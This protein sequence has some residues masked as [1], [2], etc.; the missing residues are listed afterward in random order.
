MDEAPQTPMRSGPSEDEDLIIASTPRDVTASKKK[1]KTKATKRT[2]RAKKRQNVEEEQVTSDAT[3]LL[4]SSTKKQRATR[5]T[6]QA[7]LRLDGDVTPV[8][9]CAMKEEDVVDLSLIQHP[10]DDLDDRQHHHRVLLNTTN[11]GA[12]PLSIPCLNLVCASS[13][14]LLLPLSFRTQLRSLRFNTEARSVSVVDFRVTS[15]L[16]HSNGC[17]HH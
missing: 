15:P 2:T 7:A 4:T 3:H 9:V 8:G 10:S 1:S 17:Q 13:S 11:T 5:S 14:I 6:R 12:S 16:A